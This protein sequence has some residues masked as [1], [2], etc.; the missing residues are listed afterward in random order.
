MANTVTLQD[1]V[2]QLKKNN[3]TSEKTS[4][5]LSKLIN[6]LTPKGG[7]SLEEKL[8]SSRAKKGGSGLVQNVLDKG[9]I[10]GT[11]ISIMDSILGIFTNMTSWLTGI[12]ATFGKIGKSILK[13]A[14]FGTKLFLPLTII[15]GAISAISAS[16]ESFANGD[17]WGGLE[18]AVT[19]FFNSV[20]TIPLDLIKDGIVWLLKKMG[21][22]KEADILKDFSFTE[23]FNKIIA[24]LFLGLKEAVKVVTDLFSFGEEDKTALGLLGKLTDI[25]FAPV[26]IAIGFIRGLFGWSEE[27]APAFKLQDWI[28]TKVDEAIVWVK[29]LFSWAGD[30]IAE[31]WTNLTNY[32]SE[33]WEDVKTWFNEKLTWA[34]DTIGIGWTNLTGFVSEKWTSIKKFFNEKL[35]FGL[36]TLQD[37]DIPGMLAGIYDRIKNNFMASM[38]NLAIWFMT[39]PTK[40]GLE[41]EKEWILAIAKLK[42][43]FIKFGDWIA[44]LPDSIL[45][46]SLQ[47]VK[48]RV[49]DALSYAMGID[50]FLTKAE[51]R[52]N[53]R[54]SGTAVALERIDYD[55]AK[56]LGNLNEKRQ[57]LE[58]FQQQ[59][60]DA[61][62]YNNNNTTVNSGGIVI[63]QELSAQDMF[64]GG[65][66]FDFIGAQ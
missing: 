41:L 4:S 62:T 42:T 54:G 13:F 9:V 27:G 26:N 52:V 65:S 2:A 66:R 39:M 33:K 23:E 35:G 5:N 36:E 1:V 3:V 34:T 59:L 24:K 44:G 60:L 28:T 47:K 50:G 29:G 64:N 6:V 16:W 20:V 56:Q 55:T 32:V 46:A 17:I 61:R 63:D 48:D 21:F 38:E 57:D 30:K 15:I 53:S 22:D 37:L 19:G 58:K 8:K 43:G 12:V 14:R 25:I 45:L 31:G 49:G 11:G 18:K 7:D 10:K 40:I 51:S